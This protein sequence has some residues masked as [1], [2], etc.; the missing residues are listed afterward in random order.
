MTVYVLNIFTL[1]AERGSFIK[2][3]S[4]LN[5]TPSAVSHAIVNLEKEFGFP[6][7]FRRKSGPVLT[8]NAKKIMPFV[9]EFLNDR[10][11]LMQEVSRIQK[12]DN[13][14]VRIGAFHSVSV[15]WM[16]GILKKFAEKTPDIEV[17]F[18]RGIY[19]ELVT[20]IQ[21]NILD[22]ALTVETVCAGYEFLPLWKEPLVCITPKEFIPRNGISVTPEELSEN[23]LYLQAQDGNFEAESYIKRHGVK[24]YSYLNVDDDNMMLALVDQGAGFSIVPEMTAYNKN[25]NTAVYPLEPKLERTIG[26]IFAAQRFLSPAVK[27]MKKEIQEYVSELSD[28]RKHM[29]AE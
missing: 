20:M 17:R 13:G 28:D 22:I 16:P 10:E 2:A 29:M 18:Y 3:A 11:R 12:L 19:R 15:E 4:E 7:F 8:E 14:I 6:L 26:M 23:K 1:A 27:L 5:L 9:H 24:V 21:G 25:Y